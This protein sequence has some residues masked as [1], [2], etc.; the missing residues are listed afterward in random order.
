MALR[1]FQRVDTTDSSMREMQYRLEETLRPVT[2]SSIVDGRLIEDVSLAS[3]TTSKIAHKLGRSIIGWIVVGKNAAQHVYDENSGKS[4]L[5]TYLHL[6]A[7]GT[8]TV[9]V[10]VF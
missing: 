9:N 5:G 8:V 4:D 6:T 10:W 2:D 3:G 1:S 7:S